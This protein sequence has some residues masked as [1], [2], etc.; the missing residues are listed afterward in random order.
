[1]ELKKNI[2]GTMSFTH[3]FNRMRK[4]QDFIVYP[5]SDKN[6]ST[7]K[8]QSDTRIGTINL[9]T[10]SVEMSQPHSGGAFFY[11][12]SLDKKIIS[13]LNTED[14]NK[15]NE[16]LKTSKGDLVGDSFVL[17]DNSGY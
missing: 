17:S 12:L 3:K 13:Q 2:M 16:S 15:L 11:H 7:I 1:M 14:L 6:V 9:N 4:E 10:G 8:V 5:K